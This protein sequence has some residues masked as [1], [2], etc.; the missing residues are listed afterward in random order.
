MSRAWSQQQEDVFSWFATGRGN[1]VVRARAGTG[2]TTTIIEAVTRAPERFALLAA[3]NKRISLELQTKLKV[4]EA[5]TLH[6]IGFGCVRR[7]WSSVQIDNSRGVALAKRAAGEH[8]PDDIAT[9]IAKIASLGKNIAPFAD[10]LT[11]AQIA[12]QYDQTPDEEWEDEGYSLEAV[13]TFAHKAMDLATCVDPDGE[14]IDFDDMVYVP[15]VNEWTRPRYDLVV[16]DECLEGTTPILL[17]DGRS[18]PIATIVNERMPIEVLSFDETTGKQVAKRVTN[19]KRIPNQKRT[20]R[21]LTMQCSDRFS[22]LSRRARFGQRSLV[23]TEDHKIF[24]PSVGWVEAGKLKP[25]QR[26]QL[27]DTA[28]RDQ[29]YNHRNKHSVSGRQ[30]LGA[31]VADRM[32]RGVQNLGAT[33]GGIPL[34]QKGG[35]GKGMTEPQKILLA[36]LGEGW[37]P[38]FAIA[39]GEKRGSGFPSAYKAD[40]AKPSCRVAIEL[41]G[42]SHHSPKQRAKDAKKDAKLRSLGWQVFRFDNLDAIRRAKEIAASM[43]SGCMVE[44]EVISVDDHPVKDH[45]VYDLTVEDTHCYYAHG[46]LVHNCQDMNASQLMLAKAVASGRIVCV[47]DDRQAIYGFRGADSNALDNLKRE[48]SAAEL[49]LTV[50]YR[51]PQVVVQYAQ[52]LVP[53]FM[54]HE[55]NAVG[56]MGS[57]KQETMLKEAEVGDLIL[58]RKNAPLMSL[59]LKLLRAGK[60][61]RIEGRNIGAALI[62]IVKARK[63]KGLPAL[64]E[65]LDR[66]REKECNKA[67]QKLTSK[68]AIDEKIGMINDQYECIESLMD[69]VST[70]PELIARIDSLFGDTP[71]GGDNRTITLSS[72]H[73]A[74]GL[75]AERVYLLQDTLYPG[76]DKTRIEEANLE[77]V[78]VT[79]AKRTLVMVNP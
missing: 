75:E 63:A 45:Y 30:K 76:G 50:T 65:K 51:C 56:E 1:L 53:D 17:A 41:D 11:L 39:T 59:C 2:K 3:F 6:A 44:T 8:I 16:I 32:V 42:Q 4:G 9:L 58:S 36:E 72:I 21:V 14:R 13:C 64:E 5:K 7:H 10:E 49:G 26:L 70:V 78:G 34:G 57:Q 33:G 67:R 20:V 28:P 27:E 15:L 54:A 55:S 31:L 40:I 18:I 46:V 60:R 12:I 79:R 38:E 48:L 37:I 61:A 47:G 24:V 35:N 23:C 19:W 22:P 68:Q 62:G 73:K 77:Y 52:R 69:G 25:G 43:P 74:K 66:W 29:P 71:P